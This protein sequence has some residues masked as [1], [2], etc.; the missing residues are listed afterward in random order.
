MLT[1]S[2]D[3]AGWL[4]AV[5]NGE[6]NDL[7]DPRRGFRGAA[8]GNSMTNHRHYYHRY[9]YYGHPYYHHHHYY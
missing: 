4:G 6:H 1:R 2:F 7:Q 5:T 8:I 9:G 3:G